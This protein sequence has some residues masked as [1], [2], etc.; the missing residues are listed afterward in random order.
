MTQTSSTDAQ[1]AI[2][3]EDATR[4]FMAEHRANCTAEHCSVCGGWEE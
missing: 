4:E 1:N 3:N 2:E